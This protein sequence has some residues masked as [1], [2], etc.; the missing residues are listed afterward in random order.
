MLFLTPAPGRNKDSQTEA[1]TKQ[2]FRK[3]ALS[4]VR[5]FD[6]KNPAN[7]C[8]LY[9]KDCRTGETIEVGKWA[10]PV[11]LDSSNAKP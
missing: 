7:Y 2:G 3:V 11:I 5:L 1:L 4:E 9:Q 10:V 6:P 8:T